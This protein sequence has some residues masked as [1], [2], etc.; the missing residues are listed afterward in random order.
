[1]LVKV[2]VFSGV[3]RYLITFTKK[4]VAVSLQLYGCNTCTL[5]K[6]LE[7]KNYISTTQGYCLNKSLKQHPPK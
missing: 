4:T 1:M 7:K 6:R 2:P 3:K 5:M